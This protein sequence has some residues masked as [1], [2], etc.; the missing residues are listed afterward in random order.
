VGAGREAWVQVFTSTAGRGFTFD[1]A[2]F[3]AWHR[4]CP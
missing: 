3:A 1:G 4:F 2:G